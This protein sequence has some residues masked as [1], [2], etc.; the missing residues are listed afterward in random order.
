MEPFNRYCAELVSPR[1]QTHIEPLIDSAQVSLPAEDHTRICTRP[2]QTDL[3]E[4]TVD[5]CHAWIWPAYCFSKM[6]VELFVGYFH[7]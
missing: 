7:G 2:K 5:V 1:V 6:H 4:M 3:L